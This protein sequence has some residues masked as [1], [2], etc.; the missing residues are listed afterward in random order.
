MLWGRP[1]DSRTVV[2]VVGYSRNY[3]D[4]YFTGCTLAAHIDNGQ[5]VSNDE[6]GTAVWRCDGLTA[7]WSQLWPKLKHYS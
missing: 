5:Q 3:V 6:Q 4:R 1:A 7:P 2:V